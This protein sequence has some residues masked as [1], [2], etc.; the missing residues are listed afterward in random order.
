VTDAEVAAFVSRER[1]AGRPVD[2]PE[3]VR[4]YLEFQKSHQ[5][6]W[7]V[8]QAR[9]ARTH[10]EIYLRAP[11]RPRL[12][13]E[14]DGGVALGPASGQVLVVYTNYSCALCRATHLEIDRL[15]AGT[16]VPRIVLHDFVRDSV[17]MEAAELARCASRNARS[18]AVRRV[19]LHHEPPPVGHPWFTAEE[20][21]SVAHLAGMSLSMLRECVSSREIRASIEQDTHSAR[22]LGFDDPP[23]FVAAGVPLSGMQSAELLR[24]VLSGRSHGE[25]LAP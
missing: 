9:R 19:L 14:T 4:P 21:Q 10:I 7:S 20:L 24:A 15:L 11:A 16:P 8:L 18:S 2:N 1:A 22:R 13:I 12:P 6:R 3:R 23:A 5:L 25:L 17:A